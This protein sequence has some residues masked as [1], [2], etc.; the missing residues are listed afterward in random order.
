MPPRKSNYMDVNTTS[1]F[2]YFGS[3]ATCFWLESKLE[4]FKMTTAC[5]RCQLDLL[6]LAQLTIPFFPTK[7]GDYLLTQGFRRELCGLVRDKVFKLD[8]SQQGDK[9]PQCLLQLRRSLPSLRFGSK[10]DAGE[11][12]K[13]GGG[14]GGQ[15]TLKPQNNQLPTFSPDHQSIF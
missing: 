8:P 9:C 15:G 11:D 2:M 1:G 12:I 3:V 5:A 10:P 7:I 6:C 13:P 4:Q 14:R